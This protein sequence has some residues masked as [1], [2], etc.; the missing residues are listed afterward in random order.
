MVVH[1]TDD[2]YNDLAQL[3]VSELYDYNQDE[4]VVELTLTIKCGRK[5]EIL[6][7]YSV[8]D[9]TLSRGL[10]SLNYLVIA[11]DGAERCSVDFDPDRLNYLIDI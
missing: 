8:A 6:F 7:A 2:F 4:G 5:L 3:L 9:Q 11:L 1:L 10:S